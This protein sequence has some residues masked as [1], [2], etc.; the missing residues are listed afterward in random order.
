MEVYSP[1]VDIYSL[2]IVLAKMMTN[3]PVP[4]TRGMYVKMNAVLNA[5]PIKK[6]SNLCR[7]ML[8]IN[9]EER[10]TIFQIQNV[11]RKVLH[12]DPVYK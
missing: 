5:I 8:R 4:S 10:P 9:P 11:I 12:L 1:A 6:I 7:H 3:E 2:G